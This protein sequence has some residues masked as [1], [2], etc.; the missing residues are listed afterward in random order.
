MRIMLNIGIFITIAFFAFS[1]I[2]IKH[3]NRI[4][5]IEIESTEKDLS[6]KK[7]E[8][9]KLLNIKTTLLEKELIRKGFR[10]SLGMDVPSKDKVIYLDLAK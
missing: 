7:N 2:Y 5:N 8:Y 6:V 4:M 10:E 1:V 9:K 3:Q